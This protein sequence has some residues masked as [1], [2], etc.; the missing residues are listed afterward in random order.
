MLECGEKFE[1]GENSVGGCLKIVTCQSAF[2][3][4]M[5]A[6][7]HCLPR[8]FITPVIKDEATKALSTFKPCCESAAIV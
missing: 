7:M 5:F 3:A 2:S 8:D 4:Q 1:T 6:S